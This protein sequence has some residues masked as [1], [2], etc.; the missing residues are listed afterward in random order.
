MN[1]TR[2]L[3]SLAAV[4]L[5]AAALPRPSPRPALDVSAESCLTMSD[6]P[7]GTGPSALAAL[8]RCH[9][10]LPADVELMADLGAAYESAGV[11]ER[12]EAIYARALAA[13]PGYAELRLRLGRLLLSRGALTEARRQAE[14]GLLTQPN[15][16]ALRDLL[17]AAG[18]PDPKVPE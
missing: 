18:P 9:A 12:A 10:L 6:T 2:I 11:R 5:M 13:D 7:P 3:A 14:A 16:K 1:G 8:E 4:C 15:R 17:Q